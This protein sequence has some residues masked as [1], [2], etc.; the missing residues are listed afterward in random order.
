MYTVLV[1]V[2]TDEARARSQ[3]RFVAGLPGAA[4]EVEATVLFVFDDDADRP[5]E[6]QRYKSADRIGSVRRCVDLLEAA[7]VTVTTMD[8]SG[9]PARTIVSAADELAPD[10][11]VLGGRKRS[12]VGKAIFGS[13]AQSVILNT[14]HPVVVTGV[15]AEERT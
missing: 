11:L 6:L 4:D 9:D 14:D 13:I 3:A 1:P 10:L 2:D 8:D 7:G 12:P 15:D 5:E